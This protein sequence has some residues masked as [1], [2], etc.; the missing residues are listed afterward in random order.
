MQ[1]YLRN[2]IEGLFLSSAVYKNPDY[3]ME[4][5]YQTVSLL[6]KKYHF[7][8]YIH[9]KVIPGADPLLIR[10]TGFLADRMSANI[11]LPSQE[12]LNFL[13]PQKTK[14]AIFNA[15]KSI[16]N[17]LLE[18]TQNNRQ[19]RSSFVPA[20]Q[21]TQL[22]IG[23]SPETDLTILSLSEALYRN[24]S[25]KRVYY[26]AYIPITT[27]DTRLPVQHPPLKRENRLYQ[28]DWL[29]R[30]YGFTAD[31]LLN[32]QNPNFNPDLDPKSHWALS[33]MHLFPLEINKVAYNMLIRIPG[34][35]IKSAQRIIK[36]RRVKKLTFDDLKKIGVVLKR[37]CFF[38]TCNGRHLENNDVDTT[39]IQDRLS[40]A[41]TTHRHPDRQEDTGQ[42]HLFNNNLLPSRQALISATTGEL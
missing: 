19:V 30:L 32:V 11:E 1:F 20:G 18:N 8:G 14:T 33:H 36:L 7:N 37:A 4:N 21:S 31:E 38:V 3:T 29:I 6:R 23:A 26:S 24:F 40:S 42:L 34:I 15:M 17:T 5:I 25:L 13:A 2:Y 22:I 27:S 9:V 39:I 12:S 41:R 35:G 10:K 16:R 28:A